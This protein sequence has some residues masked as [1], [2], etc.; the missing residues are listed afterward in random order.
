MS[1][2]NIVNQKRLG[3]LVFRFYI[4]SSL[5]LT[6]KLLKMVNFIATNHY[7]TNYPALQRLNQPLTQ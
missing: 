7:T 2:Q 3:L 1:W 5:K 4:C 6:K